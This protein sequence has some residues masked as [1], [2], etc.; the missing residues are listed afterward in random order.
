MIYPEPHAQS[1]P[2]FVNVAYGR[3][4]V[5]LRQGDEIP[6]ESMGNSSTL[7]MH[8][9]AQHLLPKQKRLN[10]SICHLGWW[11]GLAR[12]RV[13]CGETIPKREGAS[14]GKTCARQ[15]LAHWELNISGVHTTQADAASLQPV[16]ESIIGR[17]GGGIAHRGRSLISTITLLC[18]VLSPLLL[19]ADLL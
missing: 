6:R 10:R 19:D 3:G 18:C 8:Y 4:S 1:L 7:T 9:T 5:L 11:V 17:E 12:G 13:L 16:D 15:S 2:I 14:L